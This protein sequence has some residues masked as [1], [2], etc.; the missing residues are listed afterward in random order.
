MICGDLILHEN[1]CCREGSDNDNED[2]GCCP[3]KLSC[4]LGSGS[5]SPRSSRGRGS[6]G[7]RKIT[8]KPGSAPKK[9]REVIYEAVSD[10]KRTAAGGANLPPTQ[11]Y[12]FYRHFGNRVACN[13]NS[14]EFCLGYPSYNMFILWN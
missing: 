5:Q 3:G 4:G 12:D 7:K 14:E 1:M 13:L 2:A 9:A 11:R 8:Q 10:L 6:S